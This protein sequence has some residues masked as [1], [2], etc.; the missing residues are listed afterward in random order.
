MPYRWSARSAGRLATCHPVLIALM[1]AAIE[2]SPC[3]MTITCGHR[4]KREQDEVFN[5]GRSKVQWPNS[6]HNKMPALAVDVVPYVNGGPSW[7]WPYIHPLADHIK[8]VWAALPAEMTDGWRLEW[9]GDWRSFRDGPH[10]QI[11]A[12]D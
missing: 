7:D 3:D 4:T 10:W 6:K 11:V 8:S 5:N 1:D 12:E 2:T 9:G